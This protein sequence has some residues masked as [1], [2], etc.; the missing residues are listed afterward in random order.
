MPPLFI[1]EDEIHADQHGGAFESREEALAELRHRAL[2]PWDDEVN[3]A[4]CM[5]WTTCGRE[6]WIVEYDASSTPWKELD[7]IHALD[8]SADGLT[9]HPATGS[10]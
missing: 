4:P 9:W 8:V 6:Y 10:N 3:R 5:N 2:L 1:I 7:R